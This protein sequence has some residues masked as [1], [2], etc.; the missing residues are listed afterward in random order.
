VR[1]G[2]A[3]WQELREHCTQHE[4]R[5]ALA[6][7]E[8]VRVGRG[9]YA[10]P[11]QNAAREAAAAVGGVLS[12]L[13]AAVE[14]GLAVLHRPDAVHVT[15]PRA[16][17]RTAVPG[18]VLHRADLASEDRTRRSTTW[19]RTVLDC[20]ATLPFAEALAVA[21]SALREGLVRREDLLDAAQ[22]RRGPGAP[23]A[24]RVAGAADGDAANPFES[25]LRAGLL[26]AG[27][28]GFIPQQPVLLVTG[29]RAHVDLGDPR[30]RIALEAD[31]FQYHGT[32]RA[33]RDDCRRYDEIV[34]AGWIVLR[35]AWEHVVGDVRWVAA[36]VADV[37]A[38]RDRQ[39]HRAE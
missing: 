24:R 15:V 33:L 18:V 35:F 28:T 3:T 12:H 30:R 22:E 14:L 23:R 17:H 20:A 5:R 16:A 19:L 1:D 32:R 2:R 21:D 7:G 9:R 27:I 39:R 29:A 36:V 34:R 26:D 10:L 37:C 25:T 13:S 11:D 8:I 31:G 4:L 6:K 38:L